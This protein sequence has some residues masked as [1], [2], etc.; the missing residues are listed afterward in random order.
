MQSR[1]RA[2]VSGNPFC[3]LFIFYRMIE[4]LI[5]HCCIGMSVL[6]CDS[7]L[8]CTVTL[9]WRSEWTASLAQP[10]P[11]P[12]Y[13]ISRRQLLFIGLAL[14]CTFIHRGTTRPSCKTL[15]LCAS[16]CSWRLNSFQ[17]VHAL[18]ILP[19]HR[20]GVCQRR[21][22]TPP[23]SNMEANVFAEVAQSY[24]YTT[25]APCATFVQI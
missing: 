20:R 6:A 10:A 3:F 25:F 24:I 14:A 13:W 17:A 22:T 11:L 2:V 7:F 8:N 18:L 9:E 12:V 16:S 23:Q 15:P 5:W 19:P 21:S 1:A 4:L